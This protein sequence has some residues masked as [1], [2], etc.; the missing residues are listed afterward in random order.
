MWQQF[1]CSSYSSPNPY[2][3]LAAITMNIPDTSMLS[4]EEFEHLMQKPRVFQNPNRATIGKGKGKGKAECQEKAECPSKGSLGKGKGKAR[5]KN[6]IVRTYYAPMED[7][8]EARGNDK[9]N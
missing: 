1:Q 2:L 9:Q 3:P 6:Q 8:R 4:F 7:T 5:D